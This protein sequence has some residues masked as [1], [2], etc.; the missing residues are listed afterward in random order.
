MN[1]LVYMN[2]KMTVTTFV[3]NRVLG[4]PG[5]T[6]TSEKCT[7]VNLVTL[8][9]GLSFYDAVIHLYIFFFLHYPP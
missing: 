2:T 4:A 3:C 8:S 1:F 6:T 5:K 9:R 7:N